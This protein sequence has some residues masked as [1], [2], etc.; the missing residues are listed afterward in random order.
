MI[1]NVILDI[2]DVLL[3]YRWR[4]ILEEEGMEPAQ[5]QELGRYIF[6]HP[7]WLEM[8]YG[9]ISME[10]AQAQMC[11]QRPQWREQITALFARTQEMPVARPEVWEWVYRL[12]DKGYGIYLLSNYSPALFQC[13]TRIIPFMKEIDGQV[14]SGYVG[15]I[16]PEP[17]I[18]LYLLEKYQ[19]EANECIFFDDRIQNI[20]GA[21]KVGI[22]GVCTS[23]SQAVIQQMERLWNL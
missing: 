2:G 19:L 20:E 1:K 6:E 14:I 9:R 4:D 7:A 22:Q 13:H 17:G 11:A 15:M 8:D 16:K 18:Y 3:D 21:R 23:T 5:A 10:E 12:K